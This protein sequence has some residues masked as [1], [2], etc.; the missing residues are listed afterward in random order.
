[1][2]ID[3][4]YIEIQVINTSTTI[5]VYMVLNNIMIASSE[6]SLI[7]NI[8]F[9]NRLF[10]KK[11]YRGNGYGSKVLD[12]MLEIIKNKNIT[13]ELMINPYGEMTYEQLEAFYLRHDF[14]KYDTC[15]YFNKKE[16]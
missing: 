8:W 15:Y 3:D 10:V 2:N 16:G 7:N 14:K 13:L 6:C 5:S 11:N 1:M 4:A 12:K 9:F